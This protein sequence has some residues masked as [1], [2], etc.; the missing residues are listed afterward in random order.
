[1]LLTLSAT[2]AYAS[3]LIFLTEAINPGNGKKYKAYLDKSTI[4][5]EGAYQ[6]VKLQSVYDEPITAAGYDGVKSMV[7][8]FQ[9][10]CSRH[11]K[12]LTYIAFLNSQGQTIV[13]E[14]YPDAQDEP[15]GRDTVDA[16]I[17]PYLCSD[18]AK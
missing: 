16:K 15:I 2:V 5:R 18:P 10:D 11:V 6:T 7:N 4:H 8:T 12:K 9:I 3:E 17:V 13:D 14:K 1:V